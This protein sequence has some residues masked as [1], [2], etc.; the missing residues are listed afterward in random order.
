MKD[1][2]KEYNG[3]YQV[4]VISIIV[5]YIFVYF[6]CLVMFSSKTEWKDIYA[7]ACSIAGGVIGGLITL[8]GVKRTI[9]AQREITLETFGEQRKQEALKLIPQKL[10]ALHKLTRKKEEFIEDFS[11]E[12]LNIS[13]KIERFVE[14]S[15]EGDS[16]ITIDD[17]TIKE[18]FKLYLGI[19]KVEL[20]IR[21]K[22]YEFI[23]I[24]S[25]IDIEIYKKT[26]LVFDN[27]ESQFRIASRKGKL[28]TLY[29]FE[30]MMV[31]RIE[32]K[33]FY[34]RDFEISYKYEEFLSDL[35]TVSEGIKSIDEDLLV[36]TRELDNMIESK[37]KQYGEENI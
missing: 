28:G 19:N 14:D 25:Q 3:E 13:S 20:S 11:C 24:V 1:K 4:V 15:I 6:S 16:S 22:E 26:K 5:G 29:T 12:I 17:N 34:F 27:L 9:L 18:F 21:E 31:N 30:E 32:E 8:E 33:N 37:L 36:L 7:A 2:Q 23:E 35:I 10:V